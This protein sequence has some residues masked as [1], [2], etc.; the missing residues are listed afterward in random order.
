MA[1]SIVN[2]DSEK[3]NVQKIKTVTIDNFVR[4]NQLE[5]GL[6]KLDV[7]GFEQQVLK[8]AEE[9]ICQQKPILLIS[10]YHNADDFFNIKPWIE[11][12]NLGYKFKIFKPTNSAILAG[13]LLIAESE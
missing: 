1:S 2:V 4:E 7:E 11:S 3:N 12:L 6:I 10:I 9:T 13:M 5:I 8:G